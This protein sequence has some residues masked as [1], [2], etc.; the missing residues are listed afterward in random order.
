MNQKN[1][2]FYISCK[3]KAVQLLEEDSNNQ[4]KTPL[5]ISWTKVHKI[6]TG[7]CNTCEADFYQT[8]GD[9]K[10][11]S[12]FRNFRG[13]DQEESLEIRPMYQVAGIYLF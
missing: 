3:K 6:L 5:G 4:H 7:M 9:L 12:W 2:Q 1:V 11:K 8:K 13:A 10:F